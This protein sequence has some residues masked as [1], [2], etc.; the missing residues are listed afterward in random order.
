MDRTNHLFVITSD[1]NG[2]Q[3]E[4]DGRKTGEFSTLAEAETRAGQIARSFKPGADLH[5]ELDFKWTLSN[6][7]IR[8]A[9]LE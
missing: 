7:E 9:T 2:H 8:A 3:L 6:Q 5:F 4:V 1:S